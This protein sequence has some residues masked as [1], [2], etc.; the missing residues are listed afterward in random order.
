MNHAKHRS[1]R[2]RANIALPFILLAIW[3]AGPAKAQ[4]PEPGWSAQ[5]SPYVWASGIGGS[6]RPFTGAPTIEFNESFS[7]VLENLDAAVFVSG[8]ARRDRFV[9]LGDFSY[10]SSS[11]SGIALVPGVGPAPASGR[12]RQISATLA[13]GYRVVSEPGVNVDVLGGLRSWSVRGVVDIAGGALSRSQGLEFTDPILAVRI[14]IVP[15][16]RWS[17]VLYGDIGG[18]SVGSKLTAQWLGTAN[19]SF[20]DRLYLS[21]GYRHLELDYRD[22]GARIDVRMSGPLV[23]ATWRF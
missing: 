1:G 6:I 15:A 21:A 8:Y 16:S 14:H 3:I 10:V 2:N 22:S 7:E 18:F 17:A 19:Y 20:N 13:G 11:R 9:L 23:G 5:V 4:E 12:L